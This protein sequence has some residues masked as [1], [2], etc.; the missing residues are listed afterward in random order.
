MKKTILIILTVGVLALLLVAIAG[1][2][3]FNYLAS[4]PG[5]DVDGNKIESLEKNTGPQN[6]TY[7][8]D[9]ETITLMDGV[10]EQE[11]TPNSSVKIT[12]KYFGNELNIDLNDDGREDSVLILTQETGGS[13]TFFYIVAALNTEEGWKGSRAL[14]L[15]DRI[16]PQT[17]EISQNPSHKN[18][19]I[20][21]YADRNPGEP[22]SAQP[23]VGKS[24]WLKLDL[25]NMQF[26]EVVQNF[27]GESNF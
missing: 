17:T 3:I 5:Y 14:F 23:S 15:G 13:G 18:V 25:Q 21:N 26:G 27:E 20:V 1:M 16:A 11:I 2:Y 7:N 19:I 10:S 24:I 4:Q 9:D 22:V 6:T 12:T 8:I